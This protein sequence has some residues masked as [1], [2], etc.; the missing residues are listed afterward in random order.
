MMS[1]D[2]H[3]DI[4]SWVDFVRGLYPDVKRAQMQRHQAE[5]RECSELAAFW[6]R[7]WNVAHRLREHTAPE[8]WSRQAEHIFETETLRPI[9]QLPA[10]PA[11]L[12][13]DSFDSLVPAHVR[14]GSQSAR[15][16]VYEC[17]NCALDLKLETI[18][19]LQEMSVVGQI[20]DRR[21]PDAAIPSTPI[22]MFAGQNVI[23]STSSNEFGE[24]HFAF[25]PKRKM[26]ISFPFEG[27]RID[28]TLD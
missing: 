7:V 19:E 9:R 21:D 24:F 23:A 1:D 20:S 12:A 4:P 27:W 11:V 25:K 28:V 3:Y 22:F 8:E 15:H 10:R 26:K 2:A 14:S 5:C 17:G 6:G 13:F 16:V 18:S